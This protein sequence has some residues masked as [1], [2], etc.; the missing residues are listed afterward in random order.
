[1]IRAMRTRHE[2]LQSWILLGG[3][4]AAGCRTTSAPTRL[5]AEDPSRFVPAAVAALSPPA[6]RVHAPSAWQTHRREITADAPSQLPLVRNGPTVPP[7]SH[8]LLPRGEGPEHAVVPVAAWEPESLPVTGPANAPVGA[9]EVRAIDFATALAQAGGRNPRV[10]WAAA[11]V[12]ESYA[13]WGR[14]RWMWLP[15]IQA[16]GNYHKHEGR[17]QDV[18]GQIIETSRGSVYG[19]F[20][21]QAVGAGSPAQPGLIARFHLSDALHQPQIAAHVAQAGEFANTAT[22]HETLLNTALRYNDLLRT[23]QLVAIAEETLENSRKLADLTASFARAGQGNQADADRARTELT[24]RRSDL[25]RAREEQRVASV[26]LARVLS[27]DPTTPLLPN[28]PGLVP[29]DL[30][31]PGVA[32][33]EAVSTALAQRP[34]LGESRALVNV[35]LARYQREKHAP[36]VPSLLLGLSHGVNAG[37]LGSDLI[38]GGDRLDFDAAA[39]WELRNLGFGEHLARNEA[40]WRVEQARWRQVE[41]LDQVAAETV[42]ALVQVQQRHNRL[43]PAQQ[44]IAA[45]ED[46]YRR[47]VARIRDAQGLPLEVLQSLQS[48]DA[49]RREYVRA[50]ADY[51]E[52]QFRLHRALGWPK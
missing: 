8:E 37:G 36:L 9:T 13:A 17:I 12:Q 35:A 14:A 32:A 27:E 15:S 33:Q 22:L 5:T 16:G 1:M 51:N 19:G 18:A 31:A 29:I 20:G 41:V 49:A 43:E 23:A 11:R 21:A 48:L 26:R 40:A 30:V 10:A 38:R 28:E 45:A 50:L 34:E 7:A 46:S 52:A 4:A 47:N 24:L 44:A 39:W 25:E 6:E 3:L 2:L 42:E